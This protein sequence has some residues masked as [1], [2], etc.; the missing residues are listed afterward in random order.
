MKKRGAREVAGLGVALEL[1]LGPGD[2]VEAAAQQHVALAPDLVQIEVVAQPVG[3]HGFAARAQLDL[4]ARLDE[5]VGD[6]VDRG[7]R[8]GRSRRR[9]PR[10][11]ATRAATPLRRP[12]GGSR[13]STPVPAAGATAVGAVAGAGR[14]ASARLRRGRAAAAAE[15]GGR[16]GRGGAPPALAGGRLRRHAAQA[17]RPHAAKATGSAIGS[18]GD[19][20]WCE[21]SCWA[22]AVRGPVGDPHGGRRRNAGRATRR[23]IGRT[24]R[25]PSARPAAPHC[26]HA[27][28]SVAAAP[29]AI[30]DAAPRPRC[31]VGRPRSAAA[32]SRSRRP[33][34]TRASA[35]TSALTP[36]RAARRGGAR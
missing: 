33:R 35:A 25:V 3:E 16:P 32:P 22:A 12:A 15:P 11:A 24:A 26:P 27:R 7:R 30:A 13:P 31:G 14:A 1:R 8:A 19:A 18:A 9:S 20:G 4:A 23:N 36:R 2:P 21:S 34:P 6:A 28:N 29:P 5:L 17:A 10:T